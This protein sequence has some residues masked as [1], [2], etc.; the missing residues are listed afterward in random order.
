MNNAAFRELLTANKTT[1]ATNSRTRSFGSTLKRNTNTTAVTNTNTTPSFKPRNQSQQ[2]HK[3]R[4]SQSE[5]TA[6]TTTTGGGT[7]YRDRGKVYHLYTA[8]AHRMHALTTAGLIFDHTSITAA[9]RRL[10]KDHEFTQVE[11]V[12]EVNSSS[13]APHSAAGVSHYDQ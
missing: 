11:K 3:S 8:P 1:A 2:R 9:D 13:S 10:G 12:L 7:A 6:T 4:Q 5:S